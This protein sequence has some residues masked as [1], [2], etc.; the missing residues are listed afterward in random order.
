MNSLFSRIAISGILA[1]GAMFA[2]SMNDLTVTLPHAVSVGSTT[3]PG[4]T[5]TISPMETRDGAE[6]FVVRGRGTAPVILT[7]QKTDSA[8]EAPKTEITLSETGD[9]WKLDKLVIQGE[10]TGYE[11]QK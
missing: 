6:Y 5:Y 3:L 10:T 7:A 2:A 1:A 4:G 11:F 8:V 9:T